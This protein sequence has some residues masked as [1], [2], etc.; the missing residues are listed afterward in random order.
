MKKQIEI[1]GKKIFYSVSGNGKPVM[2]VHGFGET[3]EVWN[4]QVDFLKDHFK[5]IVPD[6]PGSGESEIIDDMSMEA[7]AD[8]LKLIFESE[9]NLQKSESKEVPL[10]GGFR[11][12][13]IGHSMGGY[14]TLA[15]VKKYSE[16]LSGFGLFHSSAFPDSDEKKDT[17]KKGIAFVRQ[18]GAFEFLKNTTPNL[19]SPISK[20]EKTELI[21]GFVRGLHN[22]SPQVIV[23]YYEAMMQRSDTTDLLKATHLP[24][25]FVI[26]KYDNA[27]PI[28]DV[29]KQA[30]LPEKS[31]IHILHQSGH[32]GMLEEPDTSNQIIKNFLNEI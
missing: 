19:F 24:V 2:L 21:D 7:M 31:Y 32:M 14:I 4:K 5:L 12:A 23:S 11:G 30:Y 16:L 1:N 10:W 17:R 28:E 25:L 22:F 8:V 20:A 29:L 6:L 3:G 27:I 9:E 18:H 15:F 13:L 26:G